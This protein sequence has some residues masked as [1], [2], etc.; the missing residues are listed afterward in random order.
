MHIFTKYKTTGAVLFTLLLL[1]LC[2]G[3]IYRSLI[4]Y[5]PITE[6]P[7][8]Y[9][10]NEQQFLKQLVHEGYK[11]FVPETEQDI[12]LKSL[13]ITAKHFSYSLRQKQIDPNKTMS[14][15]NGHCVAYSAYYEAVCNYLLEQHGYYT[16]RRYAYCRAYAGEIFFLGYNIH[17]LFHDPSFKDHDYNVIYA[18]EHRYYVDPTLYDYSGIKFITVK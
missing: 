14:L 1:F 12:I 13:E 3:T 7:I 8:Y 11:D 2:R 17:S 16:A 18:G 10:D 5:H 15:N 4:S 6:R 9:I